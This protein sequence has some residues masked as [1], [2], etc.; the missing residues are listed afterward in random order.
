MGCPSGRTGLVNSCFHEATF[1]SG[2]R[3]ACQALL[4]SGSSEGNEV[5]YLGVKG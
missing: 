3:D 4:G 5:V 2:C 1:G